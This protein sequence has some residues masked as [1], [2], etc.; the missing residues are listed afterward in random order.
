MPGYDAD[1]GSID[2]LL[3]DDI[4]FSIGC[5]NT[6]PYIFSAPLVLFLR[7]IVRYEE[8]KSLGTKNEVLIHLKNF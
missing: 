7:K 6:Q 5:K 8:N 3:N 4:Q 1:L 2:V